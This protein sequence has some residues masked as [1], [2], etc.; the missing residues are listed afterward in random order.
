MTLIESNIARFG[1][2]M[3]SSAADLSEAARL[4]AS[5]LENVP[6]AAEAYAEAHP[7]IGALVWSNLAKI[8][9]R[10]LTTGDLFLMIQA[11]PA[12]K[13]GRPGKIPPIGGV[14]AAKMAEAAQVSTRT[15]ERLKRVAEHGDAATKAAVT[16]N[17]MSPAAA[18][19]LTRY[20][21]AVEGLDDQKPAFLKWQM[22]H[23]KAD[24]LDS[25]REWQALQDVETAPPAPADDDAVSV[26][27]TSMAGEVVE[28]GAGVHPPSEF[29]AMAEA[30]IDWL[31]DN[32][33]RGL[34]ADEY[35]EI[36]ADAAALVNEINEWM[37]K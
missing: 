2:L 7:E 28:I 32:P 31:A 16:A 9:R 6:G 36:V 30:L 14:S 3:A 13:P 21:Q 29:R 26:V 5:D 33:W 10:Q 25:L 27:E 4:Y 35:G 22:A 23:G 18:E 37:C 34:T 1:E 15:V 8:G 19:E 24:C 11:T 17:T 12:T 20:Q